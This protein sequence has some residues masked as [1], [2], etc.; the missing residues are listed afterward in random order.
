MVTR[1]VS[2]D[3]RPI[4]QDLI[5][6][7]ILSQKYSEAISIYSTLNKLLERKKFFVHL[8]RLVVECTVTDTVQYVRISLFMQA[9]QSGP[10]YPLWGQKYKKL[11]LMGSR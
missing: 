9:G 2:Q 5:P 4:P 3:L 10:F 8:L 11:S 7:I 6:E 1:P